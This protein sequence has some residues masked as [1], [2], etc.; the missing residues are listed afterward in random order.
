MTTIPL[1]KPVAVGGNRVVAEV[2][3]KLGELR[4]GHL[5]SSE[6]DL[7]VQPILSA[8]PIYRRQSVDQR[9]ATQ[10]PDLRKR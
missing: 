2:S 4:A 8:H 7:P 3:L 9:V 6:P 1:A 5:A 10:P